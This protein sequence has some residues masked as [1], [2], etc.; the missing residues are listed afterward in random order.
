MQSDAIVGFAGLGG[1]SFVEYARQIIRRDSHP[2]VLA[3]Q[4][5]LLVVVLAEYSAQIIQRF[6]FIMDNTAESAAIAADSSQVSM[7]S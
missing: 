5:Q 4:V 3:M 6:R 1:E 2:I 7:M